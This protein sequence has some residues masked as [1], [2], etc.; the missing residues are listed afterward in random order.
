[1]YIKSDVKN[2][3][4]VSRMYQFIY[5]PQLPQLHFPLLIFNIRF[6]LREILLG[7]L[8]SE[9]LSLLNSFMNDFAFLI[10]RHMMLTGLT[11]HIR[12]SDNT[13]IDIFILFVWE[14]RHFPFS[15]P[16]ELPVVSVFIIWTLL[17][18]LFVNFQHIIYTYFP[19]ECF[20][21]L[22]FTWRHLFY[23]TFLSTYLNIFAL[24]LT[25]CKLWLCFFLAQI[26][27][28]N[29]IRFFKF[30]LKISLK[31]PYLPFHLPFVIVVRTIYI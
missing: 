20:N 17:F 31:T 5:V 2:T 23:S 9:L 8:N 13:S 18:R 1:M 27:A 15:N 24:V 26:V 25:I 16:S 30:I 14:K 22:A 21:S 6:I 29:E 4:P 28:C 3:Q 19:H 10:L 7:F 12:F 11:R